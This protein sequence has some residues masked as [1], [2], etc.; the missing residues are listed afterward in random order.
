LAARLKR[1]TR[2]GI[3]AL[4]SFLILVTVLIAN[5]EKSHAR[6]EKVSSLSKTD[7]PQ[8]P[9][10]GPTPAPARAG[11]E[12]PRP[13][14]GPKGMDNP[15]APGRAGL[16]PAPAPI[17]LPPA[18]SQPPLLAVGVKP[19]S[20]PGEPLQLTGG[21]DDSVPPPD[22][23]ASEKAAPDA[24]PPTEGSKDPKPE[25]PERPQPEGAP[26]PAPQPLPMPS[27][28]AEAAATPMLPP[29]A[30]AP[31]PGRMPQDPAPTPAPAAPNPV[32]A[33]TSPAPAPSS[34]APES[35]PPASTPA[36]ESR[37]SPA[38]AP[39]PEKRARPE[40]GSPKPEERPSE[41]PAPGLPSEPAGPK[42]EKAPSTEPPP[43]AAAP[44]AKPAPT[45]QP[46]PEEMDRSLIVPNASSPSSEPPPQASGP[47][48]SAP[49]P[50]TLQ[51][52]RE[53]STPAR[54]PSP[55]P[56]RSEEIPNFARS[57][58]ASEP[59]GGKPAAADAVAGLGVATG[60]AIPNAGKRRALGDDLATRDVTDD[61]SPASPAPDA[62]D[63]PDQVESVP[64]VVQSGENFWTIARLYYGSGRY[65][66]ALW[67]ANSRLVPAPEKLRVGMT[68]R[69]PPPEAL[70]RSL[71]KP[72]QSMPATGSESGPGK[73]YRRTSRPVLQEDRE[74]PSALRRPSEIE[75]ALPVADPFSEPESATEAP[76]VS[77]PDAVPE[78]R[79]RPRHPIYKV[80]KHETLRGIAR[81]TLGD[82]RRAGEILELNRDLID[83]PNV[84]TEGQIIALPDDARIGYRSR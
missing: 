44:E 27:A 26:S 37:A 31:T 47:P 24:P 82:S 11:T 70:D 61:A 13:E 32:P 66:M 83:D 30:P 5:K 59:S 33:P 72:P 14:P 81:D 78:T 54:A 73:T 2:F 65:Y 62:S 52:S 4:L 46:K 67:K 77:E 34:A 80:R 84:L 8:A 6:G 69:I 71:I 39:E 42:E 12:S 17:P 60:A 10:A 74:V 49:T 18:K 48:A 20:D 36:A 35:I 3:A 79:F 50:R 38:S 75:L 21:Q 55:S 22:T 56:A 9:P 63:D 40:E 29:Q 51:A 43:A 76:A 16:P 64:H 7:N 53:S 25:K 1:E 58:A 41:R 68:I 57:P 19:A 28:P 23:T 45:P 15:S